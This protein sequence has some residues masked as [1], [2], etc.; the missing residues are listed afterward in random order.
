MGVLDWL[1][2]G[3]LQKQAEASPGTTPLPEE[4]ILARLQEPREKWHRMTLDEH[5]AEISREQ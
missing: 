4:E 5:L 3:S 1:R 2:G